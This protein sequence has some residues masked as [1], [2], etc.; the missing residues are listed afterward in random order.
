M[1]VLF[2]SLSS[3]FELVR[4]SRTCLF[5]INLFDVR[6]RT[7]FVRDVRFDVR[8]E[9]SVICISLNLFKN[10]RAVEMFVWLL[11]LVVHLS[12]FA[13]WERGSGSS[14]IIFDFFF[15]STSAPRETGE[16][17]GSP[18][19]SIFSIFQFDIFAARGARESISPESQSINLTSC[20][21]W[22]LSL[23]LKFRTLEHGTFLII[24]NTFK[25]KD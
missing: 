3:L 20:Y 6:F 9:C 15:Q 22:A 7:F 12:V 16:N 10:V 1:F 18:L 13:G 2:C 4:C 5:G 17:A 25:C 21:F 24:Y 19:F 14:E 11:G 8:F 23:K